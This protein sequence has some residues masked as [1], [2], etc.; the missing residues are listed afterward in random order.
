MDRVEFLHN[1][2]QQGKDFPST[3]IA[4]FDQF[5]ALYSLV[6]YYNV[7]IIN[8]TDEDNVKFTVSFDES[9]KINQLENI[10]ALNNNTISLYG[11][12]FNI[13]LNKLSERDIEIIL[14][15]KT[16]MV[17]HSVLPSFYISLNNKGGM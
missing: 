5:M 11:K 7:N 4:F 2:D 8:N 12:V 13:F 9:D 17:V 1:I 3:L 10:I 14:Y 16:M 6:G 15:K